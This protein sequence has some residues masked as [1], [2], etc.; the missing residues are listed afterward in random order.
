VA[1]HKMIHQIVA[2]WNL[3]DHRRHG[4]RTRH[5]LYCWS[6]RHGCSRFVTE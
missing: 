6:G 1:I 5:A 4:E 2:V 3:E